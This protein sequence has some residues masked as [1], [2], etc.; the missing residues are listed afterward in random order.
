MI[1]HI[2]IYVCHTLC[3]CVLLSGEITDNHTLEIDL[4]RMTW[5]RH[6]METFSVLLALCAGNSPVT[7]EFP[8]HRPVTRRFDVFFDLRLDKRL[9]KQWWGWWFTW[10][11]NRDHCGVI[12]MNG[13]ESAKLVYVLVYTRQTVC[14]YGASSVK[15]DV[16]H[17]EGIDKVKANSAPWETPM[18]HYRWLIWQMHDK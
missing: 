15:G 3:T 12:V 8:A 16:L 6:Q 11:R 13:H 5:W 17:E 18:L 9:S 7:G 4:V 1:C 10:R 14:K 2:C